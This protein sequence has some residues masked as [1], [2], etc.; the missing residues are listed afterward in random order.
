[1]RNK[2]DL[3]RDSESAVRTAEG[4]EFMHLLKNEEYNLV[5]PL[6]GFS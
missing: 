3:E 1:V 4:S 6:I 5:E 2:V